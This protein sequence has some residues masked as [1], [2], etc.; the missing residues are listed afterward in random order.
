MAKAKASN[1]NADLVL[2]GGLGLEDDLVARLIGECF[3]PDRLA[4]PDKK[5]RWQE[6]LA[7]EQEHLDLIY[8]QI[9]DMFEDTGRVPTRAQ[10]ANP[11]FYTPQ[12]VRESSN[13]P[14][15]MEGDVLG[16]LDVGLMHHKNSE[17]RLAVA[18]YIEAL[19]V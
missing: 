7:K 12:L 5:E 13:C 3:N 18:T 6:G 19:K 11:T 1:R 4:F 15:G 14:A 17:P 10:Q 2:D 9:S 8:S 16:L